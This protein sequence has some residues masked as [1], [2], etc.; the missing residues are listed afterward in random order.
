M[1]KYRTVQGNVPN[2][3][4]ETLLKY[5]PQLLG[6]EQKESRKYQISYL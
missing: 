1:C 2:K 6:E 3:V 4:P 5:L